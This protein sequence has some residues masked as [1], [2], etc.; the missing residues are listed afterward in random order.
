MP[1][2]PITDAVSGESLVGTE[3][4]LQQQVDPG[5]WR[6]RLNLYTGRTLTV[7]ALDSEQNY[8]GGLL[9]T[10][11]Q[12]VTAGI[13]S[14]LALTMD[15]S[16][17]D[18]AFTISSGY[19]V[20][21]NGQD[22]VLNT[23]MKTHLSTLAVIDPV[24]GNELY[25]F[26]QSVGDPTNS[27]FAGILLLQPVI[28]QVSG[29]TL[30]TGSLPTIVS[31]NLG[32]S[33]NQDPE[34][35]AFEDWQ[36]ADAVRLVYLP[37]P[38]GVPSLP[39]PAMAPQTTWRNRLA[40]A[41]FEAEALLGPDDQL[42]WAMLGVPVAL[43]AFDPGIKWNANT[44]Y[45]VGDF[46][47][48]TNSNLQVVQTSGTSG[49]S[50]PSAWNTVFGGLTTDGSVTWV[51]SGLAWKPLFV[52]CSAVVR[53]GGLPRNK[54]I[55]PSQPAP[56]LVWQSMASF[57]AEDF[58][59]DPNNNVEIVQTAGTTG[60]PPPKWST[61][62]GQ[63]TVDGTVTWINNGPAS[64]QPNAAFAANQFIYDANNNMQHVLVAGTTGT[65]EPEWNG[66]YLPTVDGTVTWINNGS[67]NPPVV[68]Q[69]LAQ[70]RINQ[71]SEQLSQVMVQQQQFNTLA[72]IFPTL[73]PSGILPAAALNFARQAAPWLPPNWTVSAAPVFLEEL[74]TVL[75]TG[76]LM[77]PI[78]AETT[79]PEDSTL[80]EP[81][82]VLVPL[83]DA[84]YDPNIL[85][86]DTVPAVFYQEVA[87]ATEARNVTLQQL[88][89]VQQETNTLFAAVGP[90]VPTNPNWIDPNVGLTP[91]ELAGRDAPPP[92][93]PQ[94]TETFGTVL[95]STWQASAAYS[96][97]QFVIDSNGAIEV[98]LTAGSTGAANPTWSTTVADTTTDGTVTWLNNGP[99]AWQPNTAYINGQF[100]VDPEGFM[101]TVSSPGTSASA[102]P[103]WLQPEAPGQT[104]QDGGVTWQAGGKLYWQPSWQFAAGQTILDANGNIQIVRTSGVSGKSVPA[105]DPNP[106]QATEDG[107]LVWEDLGHAAWQANTA[108]SV[109]QAIIDSTG[110]VQLVSVAGTTA[111]TPPDWL[112]P[113][114]AGQTTKDGIIWQYGGSA[115]WEPDYLYSAGQLIL[116][117]S[118]NVQIVQS[119]G[120]SG[121]SVPAWNPNAGQTTQDSGV[122]W[123][124]LGH[125]AWLPGTSYSAGQAIVDPTGNIQTAT[126]G[127]TSGA[128]QPSWREGAN[129]TTQD[130][131]V[132]WTNSGPVTWQ[133]NT[134]Y[135]VG[136]I[137]IDSNGHLQ[138][139]TIPDANGN[140][141]P[142]GAKGT[143][144]RVAPVWNTTPAGTT[145]DGGV[146]WDYLAYASTDLLQLQ[147]VVS[148]APYTLTFTD[149]SQT[150]YTI[151]LL[152]KNDLN[153][154]TTNGLQALITSLNARISQ[155]NDL[156]D[157]A[158]LTAQT[159][160][161]RYRQ[162]VLGATA[163]TTLATSPVLANI[164]TGETASA[165][166]ENIQTY[167]NTLQPP[168]S[169]TT[170]GFTPAPPVYTKP[171]LNPVE[172][173]VVLFNEPVQFKASNLS[174]SAKAQSLRSRAVTAALSNIKNIGI[175]FDPIS[176]AS[177]TLSSISQTSVQQALS[178]ISG[179]TAVFKAPSLVSSASSINLAKAAEALG[180][181][182]IIA[183]GTNVAATPTDISSQSPL[184]GAQL[185]IR[186]LTIA[187]RMQQSPSQE[188]MFYSISNRL[189]FLQVLQTLENDLNLVADDLPIM[190]DLQPT[191]PSPP[192]PNPLP[193]LPTPTAVRSP[194]PT[195]SEWLGPNN[196]SGQ[197]YPNNQATLLEQIQ[198]P[199]M[200]ADSAEATFFSVGVRVLEQHTMFL[201][202]L[203]ARVQQYA[204]FVTLC[205]N[206]L[207]NIQSNIQQAQ[208]YTTQLNN[209]LL[210]DRQNVAFTSALLADEI[211]QVQSVNAQRQQVLATSV[212]LIAYTRARTLEAIDTAPSRQLVPANVTN[213]VPA[214]LQQ[215]VSIPPELREIVGQ[216]REAPVGWLPSTSSQVS[217]LERPI[218][219]QQLAINTQARATEMLQLQPL[220]S[221]AAGEPGVYAAAISTVYTANQQVFRSF[222]TQR[223]AIQPA[224]L[225]GLSWSQQVASVQS[226]AAVN[227][228]ISA[229]SVHTEVSN[230][231]T[232][233]IQQISSVATCLY[234][235]VSIEDPTDRLAWAEYLSGAGISVQLQSLAILPGWN[236]LA[237]TDRQQMQM[238]VDWLFL[239]IDTTN[240]GATAFM[241]DV[242]RTAILLASDVPVD[243]IIAGNIVA[244]V[245]PAVGGIVSL[246]LP[247]DRISAGMYV[248]MYSGAT[249]AA[250]GVVSDLDTATVSAT[251]TD[252]FTPGSY[253]ET[254]DV[255]HF[256]TL[257]PQAVALRPLLMQS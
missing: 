7:S 119:G 164:A 117:S 16:G 233:L 57:A 146:T 13:V 125:N 93:T 71:L 249:L 99:W 10:L 105:W 75:E 134:Q 168:P 179:A 52:D 141:Q 205:T 208:V 31:G 68:Q 79:A 157:T 86:V 28:A 217:N 91:D 63:T 186:T 143:S 255:A 209:N 3:P 207:N 74:E 83:P 184:A 92:Y 158:F 136:Q 242:V 115:L 234:T 159:D 219:L 139:A 45:N 96:V 101:Q 21:A 37:W 70:A 211:Q 25:N 38:A 144:G 188:A 192:P 216:L 73:P 173:P 123:Q 82:E 142:A 51:N 54:Y 109:G 228:L 55:L 20:M 244:R 236:Q 194:L 106:G 156:L 178:G 114:S 42:P 32:A 17:A 223:A 204:D 235:R 163:A 183:P 97:G 116:D 72:D 81:V 240:S 18:P 176:T 50:Q 170:P 30:D 80:L 154:L 78:A 84:L 41:I 33:C 2:T 222:Q 95:Q 112:Q 64:W 102:P 65:V 210:Q 241:S 257:T 137:I 229:D 230:A 206:A 203:E 46:I 187:E 145:T 238:L 8:R 15:L 9:A 132:T 182:Q 232:R 103:A 198:S 29:Q 202:A 248:N 150:A 127:G 129:A 34:E 1:A 111:S 100:I 43:I 151:S 138:C 19:G 224:A 231:V 44:S 66:I 47:T 237:Y 128:S 251:V 110:S 169:T 130:A 49:G 175:T 107:T 149:S 197:S 225:T 247:S 201:R 189:N 133:A 56:L 250:R 191:L 88:E 120:I 172:T 227:D 171:I 94:P 166:A 77:D 67:G 196:P 27:T 62:F 167:L 58:I 177:P 246:T 152:S 26:H 53:A 87:Q 48:D 155:A 135:E 193:T 239:Q 59:V 148:Q 180:P 11:G 185:N 69:A 126:I 140:P 212:Q 221:S 122:V 98:A 23:A 195:F 245:Q 12:S 174:L 165:T 39:L 121:D 220:P 153:N 4:Q 199:Y 36:I 256:T 22:V 254:T 35:Y 6:Q 14:G 40:Y 85:V 218:L 24:T 118:G 131:S 61:G 113:E 161:Y 147:A 181:T 214:C 108:Y 213:P 253:L 76:M 104:R 89:T 226:V 5:W 243:N 90:N 215:S 60:G 160:I 200:I 190:V 162:N 252:V 124:N